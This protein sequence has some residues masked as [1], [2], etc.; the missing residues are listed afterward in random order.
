MNQGEV[1]LVHFP[2]T[3]GTSSKVRPV[4]VVSNSQFNSSQDVTVVPISSVPSRTDPLSFFIE[5]FTAAGLRKQSSV[6]FSKPATISKNVFVRKLGKM[7]DEL[8]SQILSKL[9]QVFAAE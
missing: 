2:F 6:K 8:M 7:P 1:F 4:L 9:Y 5:D 3:D